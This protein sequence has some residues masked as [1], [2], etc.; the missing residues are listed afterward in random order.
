MRLKSSSLTWRSGGTPTT[1]APKLPCSVRNSMVPASL[2]E[3]PVGT[4]LSSALGD[5]LP[6]A[7]VGAVDVGEFFTGRDA[8]VADFLVALHLDRTFGRR[9][10]LRRLQHQHAVLVGQD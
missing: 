4:C 9:L 10:D 3:A 7:V 5:D 8:R 1:S 2:P 6:N